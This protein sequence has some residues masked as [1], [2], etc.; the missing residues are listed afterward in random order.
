MKHLRRVAVMA[1]SLSLA[2]AMPALAQDS[3]PMESGDYV[4]VSSIEVDDGHGL[5]YA[6]FLAST[7]RR[8]QE[9]AK[10]QGWITGYEVLTNENARKGEPD[11]YL[12][13]R[14]A[15]FVDK[16]EEERRA[17]AYRAHAART[18]AQLQ[19][20][21]AGRATYRQSAGSMLLRQQNFKN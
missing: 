8:N 2:F 20:E 18:I 3:W 11:L 17:K 19:A 9:F 6:Q 1:A 15:N 21:S 14:F 4:E 10:A 12:V 13:V 7:W 5:E 16:A